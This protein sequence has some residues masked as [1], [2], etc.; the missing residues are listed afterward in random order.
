LKETPIPGDFDFL[1]IDIDG[2]D[3]YIFKSINHYKPKL[4]CI[5]YNPTIP[6]DVDF[7]QEKNLNVNQ[8]SSAKSLVNLAQ[9]K[10]Y[11]LAALTECNLLF[12]RNDC[13]Q[14][15]I[16]KQVKTLPQLRD[17]SGCKIYLFSGYDGTILSNKRHV[18]LSWHNT[19]LSTDS[20]QKIPRILRTY[21]PNYKYYQII[22]YLTYKFIENP[23]Y[24]I[25]KLKKLLKKYFKHD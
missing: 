16:G 12:V 3:Y 4:I 18:N 15:V 6:N 19:N 22:I 2:C 9:K 7:I 21:P 11:L 13:R 20:I 14:D 24:I 8:G 10:G 25:V 23:K 5:E 17:D 1:S